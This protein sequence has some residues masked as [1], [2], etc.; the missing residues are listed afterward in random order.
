MEELHVLSIELFELV[1][2]YEEVIKEE[3]NYSEVTELRNKILDLES[4][5]QSQKQQF[6]NNN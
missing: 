2:Q 3:K 5:L 6:R 4:K 1:R